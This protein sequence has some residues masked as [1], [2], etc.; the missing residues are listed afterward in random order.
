MSQLQKIM[1]IAR[2]KRKSLKVQLLLLRALGLA[3]SIVPRS[4]ILLVNKNPLHFLS[5]I[6]GPGITRTIK[7]ER[8]TWP[9]RNDFACAFAFRAEDFTE[10]PKRV[11]LFAAVSDDGDGIEISL[12]PL[13][14]K[15]TNHASAGLLSISM[16][17]KSKS[18]KTINIS[19]CPLHSRVWYHVAV[20]H[21]RSRLKGVFS[22]SSKEQ[23]TVMIDGKT[24]L[25]ESIHFPQIHGD[26]SSKN[27]ISFTY[28]QNFDGQANAL[29]VFHDN[30]SDSTLKALF[31]MRM[32]TNGG[33]K[34]VS[35]KKEW[36]SRHEQVARKIMSLRNVRKDDIADVAFCQ[37]AVSEVSTPSVSDLI[38]NGDSSDVS[39]PL[40]KTAFISRL[41]L[42]WEPRRTFAD[43]YII[44]LHSG[45]HVK[46]E[47]NENAKVYSVEGAHQV[48]CSLGG[49]QSLIPII[50]SILCPGDP[51][52]EIDLP[53][54]E[55]DVSLHKL[56]LYSLV[57]DILHLLS[58]FIRSH[59]ENTRELLRCGAL[60]VLEKLLLDCNANLDDAKMSVIKALSTFPTLARLLV[61]RLNEFH[62]SSTQYVALEIALFS[63]LI[64]NIPLWF[65]S[66]SQDGG[67]A[68]LSA[69]IPWMSDIVEK[70]P[71]KVRDCVGASDMIM[72]MQNIVE[73]EVSEERTDLELNTTKLNANVFLL[74]CFDLFFSRF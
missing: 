1:S 35:E 15:T 71:E 10:G 6:S 55:T 9:F 47:E 40:T 12:V 11:I 33:T 42:V 74:N 13:Q 36:D 38:E 73:M 59:N 18:V 21:T 69:F 43:R 45:A 72:V 58:S 14:K 4:N 52:S 5:F 68:L 27:S 29:Y 22:L 66:I 26:T 44:E 30:V 2:E 24:M 31:D 17:E 32:Q 16:I 63:R 57:P 64:F 34:V 37:R 51:R 25:S 56:V 70:T 28:G 39:N 67:V 23:L 61:E 60:E 7:L 19:G 54:S 53:L 20:R 46:L 49:V 41:Y 65:G 3:A 8:S 48:I 50:C 62:S